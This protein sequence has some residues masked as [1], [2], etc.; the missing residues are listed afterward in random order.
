M[1][2][3]RSPE[4]LNCKKHK[5]RSGRFVPKDPRIPSIYRKMLSN[6]A[7]LYGQYEAFI[8]AKLMDHWPPSKRFAKSDA[9]NKAAEAWV[10]DAFLV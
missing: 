6:M 5:R 8:L 7:E 1:Y 10:R 2:V 9:R 3:E 4:C